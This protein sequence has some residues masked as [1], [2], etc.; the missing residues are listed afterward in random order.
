MMMV[1]SARCALAATAATVLV[2]GESGTGKEVVARAVHEQSARR[3]KPFVAVN[4]GAIP[5]ELLE[6]ELFGHEKGSFTG[7]IAQPPPPSKK[8]N[9]NE[10]LGR[11]S[12]TDIR[13]YLREALV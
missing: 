9:V 7:A 6:S 8:K 11:K 10:T 5:S 12:L 4:C 1:S 2:T 13:R 3:D